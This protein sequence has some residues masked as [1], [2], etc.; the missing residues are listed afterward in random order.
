MLGD[1][2]GVDG[3]KSGTNES[4]K[5]G[6][7]TLICHGEYADTKFNRSQLPVKAAITDA[8]GVHN[9]MFTSVAGPSWPNHNFAQSA[10]SCG[11]SS[12]VMYNKCGGSFPQFPQMTICKL[13]LL[14][15]CVSIC[16]QHLK[17]WAFRRRF[18]EARWRPL[19]DICKHDLW[20]ERDGGTLLGGASWLGQQRWQSV[21]WS[22][23][24]LDH[25]WG[26]K[27]C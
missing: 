6:T 2:P 19:R 18:A 20:R 5:C 26:R 11:I 4:K 17:R 25:G 23:S 21:N 3:I 22:G 9:R 27:T 8:Y 14:N 24:R 10:T 15:A 13:P 16:S 12:N 1:R 7:A